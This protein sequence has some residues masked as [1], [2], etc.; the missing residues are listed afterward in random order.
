MAAEWLAEALGHP[1]VE[2]GFEVLPQHQHPLMPAALRREIAET[3]IPDVSP[4]IGKMTT[5]D[6]ERH[7]V[8][9]A[10]RER[11]GKAIVAAGDRHFSTGIET[12][13][14]LFD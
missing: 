9:G 10:D 4:Y 12:L 2:F 1:V 13:R 5:I 3:E 8:L 11:P 6:G 7:R 14:L